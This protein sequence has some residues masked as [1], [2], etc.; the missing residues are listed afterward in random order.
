[1]KYSNFAFALRDLHPA[2]RDRLIPACDEV[3]PHRR[4]K[5]LPAR[6][7]DV[8]KTPAIDARSTAVSLRD[9]ISLFEGLDFRD[10]HEQTPETMRLIRLRLSIDPPSQFLQIDGRFCHFTPASP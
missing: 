3:F 1:L 10:M 9:T 4:K 6:G 7:L 5:R 8:R 2:V